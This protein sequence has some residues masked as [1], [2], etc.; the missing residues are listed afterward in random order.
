MWSYYGSKTN[1]IKHYPR[2]KH[3]RIIEPFAG[4]ARYALRYFDRDI[5]LVDKYDVIVKVWK[6]LQNCSEG[7]IL[8]L[9]RLKA[10]NRFEDINFDC[11]EAKMFYGFICGF[12]SASPRNIVSPRLNGR[13]NQINYNLKNVASNLFKIRHWVIQLG[14]YEEIVND[15]ATW[16]IDPPYQVGGHCYKESN[17]NINFEKLGNWCKS[18][19]GHVIVCEKMGA[20]WLNFTSLVQQQTK[21]GVQNE[22]IWTNHPISYRKE[23]TKLF[24]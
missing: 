5:L 1:I 8:K 18:R 9:P 13:P 4:S 17:K 23:Q 16:F 14:S 19:N 6:W 20:T 12:S 7:D 10:G 24:V 2:P 22:A 3:N 11:D 21:N 15:T